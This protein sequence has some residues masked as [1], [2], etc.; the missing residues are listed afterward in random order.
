M[1]S[2]I[3]QTQ[4]LFQFSGSG[5]DSAITETPERVF[6]WHE[7]ICNAWKIEL[8]KVQASISADLFLSCV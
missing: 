8:H 2:F 7:N 5:E 4:L 6:I 1:F 3:I